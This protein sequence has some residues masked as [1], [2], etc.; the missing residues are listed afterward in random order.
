[1]NK[2]LTFV[3]VH[4]F[5]EYV[6]MAIELLKIY[7]TESRKI[8]DTSSNVKLTLQRRKIYVTVL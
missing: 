8:N 3:Q 2:L 1:M 7:D 4:I 5:N 6:T